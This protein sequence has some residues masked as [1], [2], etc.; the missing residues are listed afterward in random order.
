MGSLR[1]GVREGTTPVSNV[2]STPKRVSKRPVSVRGAH[3]NSP[4]GDLPSWK[5][6]DQHA[7]STPLTQEAEGTSPPFPERY[8]T[9]PRAMAF[10]VSIMSEA[11]GNP[12]SRGA[13]F[14]GNA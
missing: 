3:R 10:E 9:S 12:N 6:M 2:L 4:P 5:S 14:S 13:R 7:R 11:A 8:S 1:V